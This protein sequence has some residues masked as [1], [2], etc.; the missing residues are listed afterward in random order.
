ML[1][2][3]FVPFAPIS[4]QALD[5]QQSIFQYHCRSW[6]R[7]SGLPSDAVRSITI[8]EEGYIWL[9]TSRGIA[10]FDGINFHIV[11][12]PASSPFKGKITTCL[13]PRKNHGIWF[14]TDGAGIGYSDASEFDSIK[15]NEMERLKRT[16]KTL[17][18]ISP[19]KLI[20]G[21]VE[22]AFSL[23]TETEQ[24]HTL[25]T[26]I[27]LDI[28]ST[29]VVSENE[30]WFGTA[31]NGIFHWK[32]GGITHFPDDSL[33]GIVISALAVDS[34]KRLWVGT[35]DGLRLYDQNMQPIELPPYAL[36]DIK[37]ILVDRDDAVWI[38]TSG[39]GLA[40]F[41]DG[42]FTHLMET[43]GLSSD[44]IYSLEESSD[45]SIWIGTSKGLSQLSTYTFPTFSY[46]E[47]LQHVSA[48][49][50]EA[51]KQ[52]GIW[53]GTPNGI[54]HYGNGSF[55]TYG[56]YGTENKFTNTW[57]KYIYAAKNG[58]LYLIGANKN[59]DHFR[60]GKI[61]NSWTF[62]IWPRRMIEDK[63]GLI[64]AARGELFRLKEDEWVPYRLADESTV[65]LQWISDL[66]LDS[67]GDLWIGSTIGLYEIKDG[68]L[69]DYFDIT[70]HTRARCSELAI[71]EDDT[72]WFA[73]RDGFGR[74]KQGRIQVMAENY[75]LPKYFINTIV[76]DEQGDFWLDSNQGIIK[77]R[78]NDLDAAMNQ[79]SETLP[80]TLF[81]GQDSVLS[82]EKIS[83]EHSGCLDQ[84]GVVWFPS[85]EGIVKVDPHNLPPRP[86]TPIV[87][88]TRAEVNGQEI[89]LRNPQISP[90]DSA[91]LQF[92]Y[93]AIDF[94]TPRQVK[95]RYRLEGFDKDW[96]DAGNR[97]SAFYTNL[98][99][100]TYTFIVQAS[101]P[102]GGWSD[103]DTRI[104]L[105]LPPGWMQDPIVRVSLGIVLLMTIS[106]LIWYYNTKREQA[107]LRKAND[108]LEE[109]VTQ[110][111]REL[112]N[113]V[114]DL[115]REVAERKRAQHQAEEL[116]E[117]MS[118][119]ARQAQMAAE[120]KSRFLAT[121]SHE[122]RTPMN[123]ILGMNDLLL[124]TPLNQEQ[125]H[126]ASIIRGGS[127]SLLN[128]L[129][130][131]L[132]F[133][134]LEA[135]KLAFEKREFKLWDTLEESLRLLN[136]RAI[137]K[138]IEIALFIDD[139]VPKSVQG[140]PLRLRQVLINLI[141]NGL[142]FTEKGHVAL[143]VHRDTTPEGKEFL[144]F[145]V[146]D[147]G[148]GIEEEKQ[149]MLFDPFYQA[150]DSS[151]RRFGGTGLGLA[152]CRQIIE[153]MG[154]EIHLKESTPSGSIFCFTMP[155]I[156]VVEQQQ[157]DSP[158]RELDGETLFLLT[159]TPLTE[160][161]IRQ[162][163]KQWNTR[164]QVYS[165]CKDL[166]DS[167][168]NENAA[169]SPLIIVDRCG[170]RNNL[171]ELTTHLSH[172]QDIGSHP[173][174]CVGCRSRST[175]EKGSSSNNVLSVIKPLFRTELLE[176]LLLAQKSKN[177]FIDGPVAQSVVLKPTP[178]KLPESIDELKILIAEDN[179][180]NVE[181]LKFQLK[182]IN[183]TATFAIHGK[184][185]LELLE[186]HDYDIILMDCQMPLMNGFE[187]TEYI[188][189]MESRKNSFIVAM[190]ANAMQGDKER[191]LAAGM[192][193][194]LSKPL[195]KDKLRT[196]LEQT[197]ERRK[198]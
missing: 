17:E 14:G 96:I 35:S 137:E 76:I 139:D 185:V 179:D 62:D 33:Y 67:Q 183:C 16:I 193:D 184:Q 85:T 10:Y 174:I 77:V 115:K 58:D 167:L 151:T 118:E 128:I 117:E 154:G 5:T 190:T 94:V 135:G 113:A 101:L 36:P 15:A 121:M 122:I 51:D 2:C 166:L 176:A 160:Q 177:E 195:S 45:G 42:K 191:C 59:I 162:F 192:D 52:E 145:L 8:S 37:A 134:K 64:L 163:G 127:E 152:I 148:I 46:T 187:T 9:G 168:G 110:R 99:P 63:V 92:D 49:A 144:R 39:Q 142:K 125:H 78:P 111:T 147:T 18:P 27:S 61:V 180:V 175:D 126:F 7:D 38:G 105:D 53:V 136:V 104:T 153:N 23:D 103:K 106:Y 102:R 172:I 93:H 196:I 40:R 181:L 112:G 143:K 81:G 197:L 43:D 60:D 141:G 31:A 189:K 91:N 82:T 90:A 178:I 155:L 129:N 84:E 188:R 71:D 74:Y 130:D 57:I 87:H 83:Y 95:Y 86:Q 198:P 54:A 109:N 19:R 25:Y 161:L 182:K 13:A 44:Y 124:E 50:V 48:I 108:K 146:C 98:P 156:S 41:H 73:G 100:A 132:D 107:H 32:D 6:D 11:E 131:I 70:Q 165:S 3:L 186:E 173:L 21:T 97:R 4:V 140:D 171:A 123:A 80:F 169:T 29:F 1:L 34:K 88:I 194:Y 24:L 26:K 157:S 138:G 158:H 72:V 159:P 47:G 149:K 116:Q 65:S 56:N 120:A 133:S 75:V 79:S 89:N 68:T 150:D 170:Y 55:Q 20:V 164:I 114:D 69:L 28:I 30:F 22:G 66:K 12:P 119:V